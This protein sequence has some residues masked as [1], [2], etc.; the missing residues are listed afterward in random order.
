MIQFIQMGNCVAKRA[1]LYKYFCGNDPD[2]PDELGSWKEDGPPFYKWSRSPFSFNWAC[3]KI[4]WFWGSVRYQASKC[5][6]TEVLSPSSAKYWQPHPSTPGPFFGCG[7]GFDIWHTVVSKCTTAH[8]GR[9]P[10][11]ADI[12]CILASHVQDCQGS[13][14]LWIRGR[15]TNLVQHCQGG[16]PLWIWRTRSRW[17]GRE[18]WSL[19]NA[20]CASFQLASQLGRPWLSNPSLGEDPFTG[21]W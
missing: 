3:E 15:W 9:C 14:P 8:I 20:K 12:D 6:A 4:V 5:T 21:I 1:V 16:F 2:N 7:Y 11:Q 13:S 19:R 17:I 18:D 10:P